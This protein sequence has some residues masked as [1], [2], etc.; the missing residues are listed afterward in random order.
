MLE[1][2][3]FFGGLYLCVLCIGRICKEGGW[4]DN[5]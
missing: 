2:L 1:L 4:D 3:I 5:D